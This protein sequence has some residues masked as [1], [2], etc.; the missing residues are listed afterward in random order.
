MDYKIARLFAEKDC[1]AAIIAPRYIRN[2]ITGKK[3]I[4]QTKHTRNK[5]CANM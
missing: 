1:V 3:H 5:S 2:P 4:Y